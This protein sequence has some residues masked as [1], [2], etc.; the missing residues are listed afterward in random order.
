VKMSQL[1]VLWSGLNLSMHGRIAVSKTFLV[2][3]CNYIAEVITPTDNQLTV[4]QDIVNNFVLR[5]VPW[6]KDK[7]YDSPEKGGLGLIRLSSLFDGLKCNWIKRIKY[8]GLNDNWKFELYGNFFFDHG[9]FRNSIVPVQRPLQNNIAASF[10]KFCEKF[11]EKDRN[12][13]LAPI[14]NN[15]LFPRGEI[16]NRVDS[17]T[18]DRSALGA[19]LFTTH[20]AEL[21]K[22]KFADVVVNNRVIEYQE[23]LGKITF[24]VSFNVYMVIRRAIQFAL[25]KYRIRLA[26]N[27]P[28]KSLDEFLNMK[29]KGS[30]CFRKVL[31]STTVDSGTNTIHNLARF[32]DIDVP[33]PVCVLK[34]RG[35]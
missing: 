1:A 12:I 18:L 17:R 24:Y 29:C 3:Q 22:L 20:E 31:D 19:L 35:L 6:S 25:K 33:V 32:L 2:S 15:A 10:S 8:N 23:L 30:K 4:M 21:L 26:S 5:G 11:W 34:L 13:L 14:I 28:N 7:L 27:L 9:N 16:G